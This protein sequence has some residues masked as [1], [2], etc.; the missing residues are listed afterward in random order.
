M[1]KK[2]YPDD[3]VTKYID[4]IRYR[5]S[6]STLIAHD[7]KQELFLYRLPRGIHF[8]VTFEEAFPNVTIRDG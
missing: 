1:S 2:R 6:S 7:D 4:G 8:I 5:V 3:N